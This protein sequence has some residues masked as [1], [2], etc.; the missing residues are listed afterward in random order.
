MDCSKTEVFFSELRRMCKEICGKEDFSY[1][2]YCGIYKQKSVCARCSD[3]LWSNPLEAIKIVQEWSDAH[4][5]KTRLSV[6]KEAFPNAPIYNGEP[7]MCVKMIYGSDIPCAVPKE[8]YKMKGDTCLKC[9][10]TP[11]E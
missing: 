10:N 9:W 2:D 11:I 4:P 7:C 5:I 3:W 8:I 1:Q 6:L